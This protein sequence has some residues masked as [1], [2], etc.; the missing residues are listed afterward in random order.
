MLP[1][2]F[3]PF[4][5]YP[6]VPGS[7]RTAW[8]LSWKEEWLPGTYDSRETLMLVCGLFLGSENNG[9]VD[10]YLELL[11]K[12]FRPAPVTAQQVL[13]GWHHNNS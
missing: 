1:Q 4:H 9:L 5:L 12:R 10:E 6:P 3:G 8:T 13:Q 7:P 2:V 11:N